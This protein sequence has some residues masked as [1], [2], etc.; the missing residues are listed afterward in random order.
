MYFQQLQLKRVLMSTLF[1]PARMKSLM[2][3]NKENIHTVHYLTLPR[4]E[5]Y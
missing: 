3:R 2:K 1:T 4:V 5:Y